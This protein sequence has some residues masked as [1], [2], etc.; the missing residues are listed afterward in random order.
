[1]KNLKK[2]NITII[3]LTI[4]L[5]TVYL[6]LTLFKKF[7]SNILVCLSLYIIVFLPTII[8]KLSKIRIANSV[9][10]VYLAF[11]FLAQL[12]GSVMHFYGI[13][14]WYDSLVHF[15]SG[16][17]TALLALYLL[18]LFNKY[19]EKSLVFNILYLVSITLMIAAFWEIFE[20]S[21]DSILGGNAQRVIE[22][23]VTDTMKDMICALLGCTLVCIV[24]LYE[25]TC[26]V[27]L[28]INRFLD[29]IKD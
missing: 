12:L 7:D 9:E 5:N 2:I 13:I 14:Y 24:Y 22:T 10:L 15:V 29:N 28:I 11:I 19:D 17:L 27:K 21:A 1:M 26:K 23:G 8:R 20:F 3:I 18:L 6:F 25:Q 4:V 16:I